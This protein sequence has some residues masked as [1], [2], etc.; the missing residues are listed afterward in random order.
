MLEAAREELAEGVD[1]VAGWVETHGRLEA[2]V[3]LQGLPAVPPKQMEYR[4]KEFQEMDL[5]AILS[6]KP[7]L[8]LVD[9]LAHTN[10]PGSRHTRRYQDVQE[11]LAAGI[12]VYTT[13]NI[14]HLE[15]LNDVVAKI[16]G[17]TVRETVPDQILEQNTQ[18]QLV[19]IRP[20]ELMQRLKD[21]K[22]YVPDQAEEAM[23][24]FFRP[25]NI[26]ALRELAL[27]YT[28]RRVDRQVESY[29]RVH[30]IDG[31]WPAGERVMFCISSSPFAAQLIRIARRMAEGLQAEWLAVYVDTPGRF[32]VHEE[33]KDRLAK[34]LR[35]AEDLGAETLNI[36]PATPG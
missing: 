31:P 12:D 32:P 21:G 30:G 26:N 22:V 29:M 13:V 15:T 7:E 6:R 18:I 27:R 34:N 9:E 8:A 35:L 11:L 28:A 25:G 20:E 1:V 19:D 23:R 16:T 36:F 24:R 14:Q 10:I 2:E 3:L 5:D 4:G 17:V 33:E